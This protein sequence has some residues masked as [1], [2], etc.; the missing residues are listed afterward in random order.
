MRVMPMLSQS[1]PVTMCSTIRRMIFPGGASPQA[2]GSNSRFMA[3][4]A[5][6][7]CAPARA[8]QKASRLPNRS[9]KVETD[10]LASLASFLISTC[11]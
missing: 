8:Y 11:S 9:K 6:W 1:M 2:F 10:T 5:A 4:V 3:L 7:N